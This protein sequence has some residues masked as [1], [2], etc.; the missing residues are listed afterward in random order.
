[1]LSPLLRIAPALAVLALALIG[2]AP[3][4][5]AAE[6]TVEVCTPN[7][8]AGDGILLGTEGDP[9]PLLSG[10]CGAA[11]LGG[12]RQGKPDGVVPSNGA[13]SWTVVAPENTRITALELDQAFAHTTRSF[14]DWFLFSGN[15]AQLAHLRD[16]RLDS[17]EQLPGPARVRYQPNSRSLTGVLICLEQTPLGCPGGEFV[18]TLRNLVA[19]LEDPFAPLLFGPSLAGATLRGVTP[20]SYNA[21]DLGSGVAGAALIVDGTEQ[22]GVPDLN[23]GRCQR[24]YRFLLPCRLNVSSSLPLDTTRLGDG[25]HQVQVVVTDAAGQRTV[26]APVT[27]T[28]HNAPVATGPPL[29]GGKAAVGGQ[30]TATTGGWA[31]APTTFAYQWLRCPAT[32]GPGGDTSGCVPIAGATGSQYGPTHDDADQRNLVRVTAGN[33]SGSGSALSAPSEIVADVSAPVLTHVSLSRKR[34]RLGGPAAAAKTLL[35]FSSTEGGKL[36]I[37]IDRIARGGKPKHV[38]TLAATVKAGRSAVLL[39]TSVGSKTLAPGRYRTTVSVRD[40]ERNASTPVR[41]SFLV[42]AG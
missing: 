33:A 12:I 3:P 22:P 34:L 27:F 25:R 2:S 21:G 26:S 40:A 23:G 30:L 4:A 19:T 18:V 28:V 9:G 38:A 41:L 32:V 15:G 31:G 1:M 5:T 37:L 24:P 13:S 11:V 42:L 35:R 20:V 39:S 29:I 6:Y 36:T 16:D 17:E 8:P 7:A 10:G 14:L